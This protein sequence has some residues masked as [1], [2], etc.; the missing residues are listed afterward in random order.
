MH[1]PRR[2]VCG[3]VLAIALLASCD[4]NDRP[5]TSTTTPSVMTTQPAPAPT[6]AYPAPEGYPAPEAATTSAYPAPTSTP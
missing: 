6:P 3:A 2:I 1:N 4:V 5:A